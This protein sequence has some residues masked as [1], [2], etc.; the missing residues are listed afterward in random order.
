[1]EIKKDFSLRKFNTFNIDVKAKYFA[2]PTSADE[3]I[4]LILQNGIKAEKSLIVGGGSNLLF[5]TDF[6][7]LILRPEFKG[8]TIES[9][10]TENVIVQAYAS[11]DWD[12]FVEWTV[13]KGFGG[14]ENLSK[15]PGV[16]GACP[17]QNIG[18]YGVEVGELIEKVEVIELSTGKTYFIN[19]DACQFE[20]RNSI[21]KHKAKGKYV[22]VSVFFKLL[23]KPQFKTH[24]GAVGEEIKRLGEISLSNIRTAIINIRDSKLPDPDKL[25]NAGSFFKN[26]VVGK[27]KKEYLEKTYPNIV[28]YKV[29]EN[30]FKIAAGWMIDYLGWKGK[31]V[32]GAAVHQEQALVIVNKNNAT[33]EEIVSLATKIKEDVYRAFEIEL[34]FEVNII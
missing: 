31:S 9:E 14:L 21:F 13:K 18:A 11:E 5:V 25:P 29:S 10:N 4:E 19:K 6:D 16:V 12:G 24:Y 1:M 22:I 7:G 23:K 27:A 8:I 17:V 26:P 15:I 28:A 34:E 3:L 32:G 2:A 30:E 33:G 20:Y